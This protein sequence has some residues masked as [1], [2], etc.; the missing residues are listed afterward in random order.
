VPPGISDAQVP[1]P[2][3]NLTPAA[4]IDEGNNWINM[5]WGPLSMF[6]PVNGKVLGNYSPAAGS[7]VIN[8]IPSSSQNYS[9]A[10]SQDFFGSNRKNGSVDAGAVEFAAGGG[11]GGGGNVTF[12]PT[13]WTPTATRGVGAG[14]FCLGFNVGPC[15]IFT[16]TNNSGAGLTGVTIG[17]S[18]T[19]ASDYSIVPLLSS[20]GFSTT[21]GNGNSC[22]VTVQ[23]LPKSTDTA[24]TKTATV[25]V[26]DSAGTQSAAIT[27]TAR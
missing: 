18:G 21:L 4:T 12:T 25:S 22:T 9:D 24:G 14:I 13:T 11:G 6:Q 26:T 8:L 1:N 27:G 17:L 20:C 16:L 7:S 5:S 2:V 19:N 15:Q 23:F 3:F 10:P